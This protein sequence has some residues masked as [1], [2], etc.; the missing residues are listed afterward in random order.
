MVDVTDKAITQRSATAVGRIRLTPDSFTL[1]SAPPSQASPKTS[2]GVA[3]AASKGAVLHTAQIAA[4]MAAKQTASLIPLCHQ[5]PLTRVEVSFVLEPETLSVRCEATVACDGKTGVEME[6]LV[7]VSGGLLC[8][9]D[10]VKAVAGKEMRIGDVYVVKKNGG[11]SGD[12][13]RGGV[14]NSSRPEK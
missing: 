2:P 8:V 9:W 1:I 11:K 5:V 7:A 4:T 13:T 6:A 3:K 10:M 14:G 12:W